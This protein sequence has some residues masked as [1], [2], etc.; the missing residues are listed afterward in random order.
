M[1]E[2]LI[3]ETGLSFSSGQK[4]T[5]D[6]INKMNDTIN[7]LVQKVNLVMKTEINI[8]LELGDGKYDLSDFLYMIPENRRIKGIKVRF[9]NKLGE[10]TECIYTGNDFEDPKSWNLSIGKNIDGGE[11]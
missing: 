8:N 4:L 11:W 9:I 3:E 1:I 5:S 10:W 6:A 7:S 2:G